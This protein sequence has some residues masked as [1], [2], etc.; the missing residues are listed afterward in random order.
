[1]VRPWSFME[2]EMRHSGRSA[3]VREGGA[4]PPGYRRRKGGPT[5]PLPTDRDSVLERRRRYAE[6]REEGKE[7]WDASVEAGWDPVGSARHE[8][9]YQ[10]EKK[11][12]LLERS[13][14]DTV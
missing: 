4:L 14:E 10:A 8:R 3:Y 6:A 1:M 7:P 9:W 2:P 11:G 5:H 12:V 13:G